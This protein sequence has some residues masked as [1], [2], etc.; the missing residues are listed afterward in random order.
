M[1]NFSNEYLKR[2]FDAG[3]IPVLASD[4]IDRTHTLTLQRASPCSD[5]LNQLYHESYTFF[6]RIAKYCL[7]Y[8]IPCHNPLVFF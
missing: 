5:D 6:L 4:R 2:L 1:F 8:K 3:H 7:K